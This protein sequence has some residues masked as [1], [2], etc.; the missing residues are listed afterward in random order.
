[1]L[2]PL[3]VLVGMPRGCTPQEPVRAP[4][5]ES[6][7]AP[8]RGGW[9]ARPETPEVVPLEGGRW[10]T[11]SGAFFV[12]QLRHRTVT[13]WDADGEVTAVVQAPET[14]TLTPD[15]AWVGDTRLDPDV[16][17]VRRGVVGADV[18]V[19]SAVARW[20]LGPATPPALPPGCADGTVHPTP[21]GRVVCETPSGL[22]VVDASGAVVLSAR[23]AD[24]VFLSDDG[25]R[26]LLVGDRVTFRFLDGRE[27]GW[28]APLRGHSWA[29]ARDGARV[30]EAGGRLT[31]RDART[32]DVVD[33]TTGRGPDPEPVSSS[34]LGPPGPPWVP[35]RP[36]APRPWRTAPPVPTRTIRLPATAEAV[37]LPD[38]RTGDVWIGGADGRVHRVDLVTGRITSAVVPGGARRV[39]ATGTGVETPGALLGY[40]LSV[41]ALTQGGHA[42]T[43]VTDDGR[44]R[45]AD[46]AGTWWLDDR[47]LPWPWDGEV[48]TDTLVRTSGVDATWWGLPSYATTPTHHLFG[49]PAE[50]LLSVAIG[51]I[52]PDCA[53]PPGFRH[54]ASP[55]GDVVVWRDE[56]GVWA[57]DLV[58]CAWRLRPPRRRPPPERVSGDHFPISPPP[59]E[60]SFGGVAEQRRDGSGEVWV[61]G[62]RVGPAPYGSV[63]EDGRVLLPLRDSLVRVWLP[64]LGVRVW[65]TALA[66]AWYPGD[67]LVVVAG[68][69][70]R[71]LDPA[72]VR[73]TSRPETP[74]ERDARAA[75]GGRW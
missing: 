39:R 15:G 11:R 73:R 14:A 8:P 56:D 40:D 29:I 67:R 53:L 41:S 21:S 74:A 25:Q 62:V 48:P 51:G 45:L 44:V 4:N 28:W 46:T 43:T 42:T 30:V 27:P 61:R 70:V 75:R 37:D 9:P 63:A 1:M 66:A 36:P 22:A 13:L 52:H 69:E 68:D 65:G 12:D 72:A 20:T 33:W 38:P 49:R 26:A 59:P 19:W 54:A 71:I 6:G 64:D 24:D 31:V 35:S 57:V 7:G 2:L 10:A 34:G 23:D 58:A 32:G 47:G 5:S 55:S 16:P 17:M 50:G 3:S 60:R 18:E